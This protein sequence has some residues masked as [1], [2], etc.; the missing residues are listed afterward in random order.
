MFKPAS[1]TP[2]SAV[3]LF[4]IIDEIGLPKGTANLVMGK[5]STVGRELAQNSDVDMITFTGSTKVG[6]GIYRAASSNLK[7]IGLELGGKSP[8]IIFS[9]ADIDQ[10]VEWSMLGVFFNQGE[11]CSATSRILV[12]RSI[13]GCHG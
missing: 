12:E 2:L 11:V 1:L 7:K 4:E 3:K 6:Q 9:S 10:A 5:G 13:H 8:L